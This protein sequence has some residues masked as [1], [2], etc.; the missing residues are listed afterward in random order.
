MKTTNEEFWNRHEGQSNTTATVWKHNIALK[1]CAI[2]C[3]IPMSNNR[4]QATS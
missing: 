2:N 1:W 3:T 4:K